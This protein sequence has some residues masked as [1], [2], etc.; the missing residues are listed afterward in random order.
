LVV[1]RRVRGDEAGLGSSFENHQRMVGEGKLKAYRICVRARSC[2]DKRIGLMMGCV[3]RRRCPC[4]HNSI[5]PV[6]QCKFGVDGGDLFIRRTVELAESLSCEFFGGCVLWW[7]GNKMRRLSY[8]KCARGVILNTRYSLIG[9]AL[10]AIAKYSPTLFPFKTEAFKVLSLKSNSP[11]TTRH[12][13][14][15]T[16]FR[17]ENGRKRP[18]I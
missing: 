16:F 17:L 14:M 13:T 4:R 1:T 10:Y 3:C 18:C 15:P 8:W 11:P 5:P 2:P 12:G 6:M 9:V 7:W